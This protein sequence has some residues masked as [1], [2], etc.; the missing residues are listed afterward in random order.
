MTTTSKSTH[1]TLASLKLPTKM[2]ALILYA[3][4]IVKSMTGNASFANPIPPITAIMAAITE[5]QTAETAA[6]ARTKGAAE[7][8]NEKRAALVQVL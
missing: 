2:P 7:T 1:R 3:Q 8:R 4:G 6:L 5:F